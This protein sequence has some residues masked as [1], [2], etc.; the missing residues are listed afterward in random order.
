MN[1]TTPSRLGNVITIDDER[2]KNHLDRVV[3]GSVS[4]ASE[5]VYQSP[6]ALPKGYRQNPE[7]ACC[8]GAVIARF[9]L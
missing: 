2:I 5:M 9:S 4:P 7:H 8:L 1:E 3:R 6:L